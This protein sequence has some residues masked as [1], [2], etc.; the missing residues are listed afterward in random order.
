VK[1]YFPPESKAAMEKLVDNLRASLKARLE[2]LEWMSDE[3]KAKAIEKW[4]S[5]MPK[6]GYPDKWRSW[7]GLATSRD[8]Y[9]QNALAAAKFNHDWRMGKIGKPV[10]RTEWG[11]TPQ[12]VNAYYNPSMNE[13][14]F[15]AAILQP[16]FFDPKADP[17][18]NYGGIGAVIGH[19]MLHGYDDQGAQFD[20]KGNFANWWQA[21]DKKGFEARTA[22][23]VAQFDAYAPI[24]AQ[25]DKH[26]N[27]KLTL[28]ENIGDLGGLSFAY[29]ALHAATVDTP[30]P[31]VD[32]LSRDQ[33]FFLNWARVWRGSIRDQAQLVRLNSDSHAPAQFRAIGA[34]SNMPAFAAAFQ[35]KV[36][37]AMVRPD[38]TRVMIW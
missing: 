16:P 18:L 35:C 2:K 32:G 4:N 28:G 34:P 7:D 29:D 12:T 20:A 38:D 3:T 37:D 19:E 8:G 23:L 21:A 1:Q 17:A 10:D 11:M 31:M 27:G 25:P 5:F 22:K 9:A 26:V 14:V 24:P 30:D 6:I 36:G 15:P 33:R 13:V